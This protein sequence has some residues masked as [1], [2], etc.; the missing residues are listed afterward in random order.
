M[1]SHKDQIKHAL[2]ISMYV[3]LY[4]IACFLVFLLGESVGLDFPLQIALVALILLTWPFAI[5]ISRYREKRGQGDAAGPRA[6]KVS[7]QAGGRPGFAAPV[8][9]YDE[10]T[11]SAEEAVQWLRG[12]KLAAEK[13]GDAIYK[14]PWFLIAGPARSGK[15]SMLLSS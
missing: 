5:A 1:T 15:T 11:R 10:L 4:S 7:K 6:A 9:A 13:S 14:L 2:H 12:T 8:R 3:S